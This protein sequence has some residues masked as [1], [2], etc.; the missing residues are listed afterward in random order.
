MGDFWKNLGRV[1]EWAS[2]PFAMALNRW[3]YQLLN[4][5][6]FQPRG[7][8]VQFY[9]YHDNEWV[10][11]GFRDNR[12]DAQSYAI[13]WL[14]DQEGNFGMGGHPAGRVRFGTTDNLFSFS[15]AGDYQNLNQPLD[16]PSDGGTT[17]PPPGSDIGTTEPVNLPPAGGAFVGVAL[18]E[19]ASRLP[20]VVIG[21]IRAVGGR[22]ASMPGWVRTILITLGVT[23]GTDIIVG[24]D[25]GGSNLPA[26]PG[27]GGGM[28]PT[29]PWASNGEQLID[30]MHGLIVN[31][32]QAGV[33][34][35]VHFQDGYMA[36]WSPSKGRWTY[37]KPRKPIVMYADGAS[38]PQEAARAFRALKHQAKQLKP[39]VDQFYKRR[40][41]RETKN[42]DGSTTVNIRS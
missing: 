28:A 5:G 38:S 9:P 18:E 40:T 39:L 14:H 19:L 25:G 27:G 1:L 13:Q 8:Y 17:M 20:S 11:I 41:R 21:I 16:I 33:I 29:N 24:N 35:M 32:W 2:N 37:W 3:G 12:A 15:T 4:P 30:P 31:K 7:V 34:P 22:W 26:L 10:E 23:E 6:A 42:A 36:A